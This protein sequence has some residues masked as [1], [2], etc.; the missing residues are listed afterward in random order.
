MALLNDSPD[1]LTLQKL[2]IE[3]MAREAGVS[4]TTIYRWWPNKA[5]VVIETFLDNHIARTKVR[6]DLPP[7]EAIE[8]HLVSVAETYATHEG[9]LVAQLIAECQ[10][11]PEVM[12]EFK[13]RFWNHRLEV[14][15]NLI[16]RAIES[17]D[18]VDDTSP[19]DIAEVIYSPVYF[20]LLFAAGPL[21][22]EWATKHL[23]RVLRGLRARS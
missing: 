2:S 17:G 8:A 3:R 12:A 4:K 6:E 19:N 11:D 5:A 23:A 16:N 22:R 14:A 1:S 13:E 20:R 18:L 10:S 21:D 7:L 15:T 9:K